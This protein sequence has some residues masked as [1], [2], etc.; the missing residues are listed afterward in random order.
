MKRNT[1]HF[2]VVI[3]VLSLFILCLFFLEERKRG[4]RR[5]MATKKCTEFHFI[6]KLLWLPMININNPKK[7]KG[8]GTSTGLVYC[9]D[10]VK[11]TFLCH[12]ELEV[13]NSNYGF[14]IFIGTSYF[15]KIIIL[16]LKFIWLLRFF[17]YLVFLDSLTLTIVYNKLG[18]SLYANLKIHLWSFFPSY[19]VSVD[20]FVLV[21]LDE[22]LF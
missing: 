12:L 14:S 8:W 1:V 15:Q 4:K 11:S 16:I 20:V 13:K 21:N 6:K 7:L 5:V 9:L 2:F 22:S 19:F 3:T 10:V 18:T 17:R